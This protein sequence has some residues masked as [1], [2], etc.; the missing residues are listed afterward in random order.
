MTYDYVQMSDAIDPWEGR[1]SDYPVATLLVELSRC[2]DVLTFEAKDIG[3]Q[4]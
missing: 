3:M 4:I 1:N 2:F